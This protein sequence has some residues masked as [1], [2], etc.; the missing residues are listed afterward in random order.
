MTTATVARHRCAESARTGS[1][2]TGTL[3]LLRLYLRRDRIVGPLWVLLLSL[4]LGPT[5]I[6]S[7][8]RVMGSPAELANYA[9][10]INTS[11][12]QLAMYGPAYSETL[13]GVGMWKA[14][15]FYT[16]IAIAT[17]L[18]LIRHTRAEEENGREELVASTR[19]GRYANTTA[20][21]LLTCGAAL[22]TGLLATVSVTGAGVPGGGALAF[23]LAMAGCGI[24]FAGV[25]AVAAQLSTSAR[26]ARGIAFAVLG[27]T[28]VL[29]AIGDV[30]AVDGPAD[31]FTWLS[32]QGWSLQTRPFAEDNLAV[33]GLHAVTAAVLIGVAYALLARRDLGAGLI[34]ERPGRAA[35]GPA[36]AGPFGLAWRLQRGTLIAWT[37]GL[38]LY[39]LLLGS[40]IHEVSDSLG[41]NRA[42]TDLLAR[43]GGSQALEDAFV[44]MGYTALGMIAAAYAISAALRLHSE[45][46]S[47]RAE[48]VLTGS[49]SRI[50][51]VASHL[52]FAL[53]GPVVA[54]LVSGLVGGLAYGLATHDVGGK[55]PRVLAAALVQTPII[56]LFAGVAMVL[57]GWL[58]RWAPVAWGV[59]TAGIALFLLGSL[60]GMPGW[61]QRL[62]PY[63]HLPRI[64]AESFRAAPVSI[65]LVAAAALIALGLFG[66]RRRDLRQ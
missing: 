58:P 17:I 44:A 2:F 10:T 3:Q 62:D 46:G 8:E 4:P 48:S 43:L 65:M 22:L 27:T 60:A 50:R 24:V 53:L 19:I 51:W 7:T 16:F 59:F 31:V 64:P 32:P 57:F 39:G 11:P 20:A 37:V 41:R 14:G 42:L 36:L 55:L 35:A 1:N 15:P 12:A 49:V 45:E 63:G 28:F 61:I 66:F 38:G 9:H 23:G 52:V 26:T 6:A 40:V 29:R 34:A 47:Q 33:L 25:A 21:L 54:L 56:W 13:G 5:Y 30:R 18:V